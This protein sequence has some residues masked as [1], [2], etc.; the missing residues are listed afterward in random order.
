MY[1]FETHMSVGLIMSANIKKRVTYREKEKIMKAERRKWFRYYNILRNNQLMSLVTMF[2]VRKFA[3]HKYEVG[4]GELIVLIIIH[5]YGGKGVK[6]KVVERL[7]VETGEC[8]QASLR[9]YLENLSHSGLITR[10][11]VTGGSLSVTYEGRVLINAIEAKFN[12][13]F[14]K[15]DGMLPQPR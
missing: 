2:D 12:T 11:R 7:M 9:R 1:I 15:L 13:V 8:T 6:N 5:L 14:K 3:L 10:K 4:L